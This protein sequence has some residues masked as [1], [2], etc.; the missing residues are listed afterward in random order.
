MAMEL[1]RVVAESA[2]FGVVI[3]LGIFLVFTALQKKYKS[4]LLSPLLWTIVIVIAVL[5]CLGI[6]YEEYSVSASKISFFLTP[7]TICYA[8]PLYRRFNVLKENFVAV[9]LG[10]TAGCIGHFFSIIGL[11]LLFG[12]DRVIVFSLVPK[13]I[14]TA[15]ALGVCEEIGGIGGITVIG[16]CVA[17]L[18]GN[19]F[20]KS[21]HRMI[22]LENKVASGLAMGT[23][24]HALGTSAFDP[25]DEE[26]QLA[27]SS[28]A[29]VVAGVLTA[30]FVPILLPLVSGL[31]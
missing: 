24:S 28:L 11:S 25:K 6:S 22:H 12:L 10:I 19:M 3:S 9:I 27:M 1:G 15:I 18:S 29:I 14:T 30:I 13:S 26:I 8:L 5:M 20:V 21:I 16:V 7:A 17:G 23:S 4:P 31:F 2:Y